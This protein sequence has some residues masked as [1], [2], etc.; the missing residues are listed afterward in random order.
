MTR[1]CFPIR[2]GALRNTPAFPPMW[3][4]SFLSFRPQ[5]RSYHDVSVLLL[6]CVNILIQSP[7]T[8]AETKLSTYHLRI[9]RFPPSAVCKHIYVP[10]PV[11]LFCHTFAPL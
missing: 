5:F 4:P 3:Q 2:E 6:C 10:L 1:F 7:N 9:K 8:K 11:S